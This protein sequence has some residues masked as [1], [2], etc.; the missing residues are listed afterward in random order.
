MDRL[1]E[2][3]EKSGVRSACPARVREGIGSRF[4][5]R[6]LDKFEEDNRY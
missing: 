1:V 2:P 4:G 3:E 5:L 6:F